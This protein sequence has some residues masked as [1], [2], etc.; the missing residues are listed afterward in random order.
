MKIVKPTL[1]L[2]K[3][4]CLNNIKS[5][6]AKAAAN[7]V[8][9]RPHFKT[10]QS[11]EVAEWFR[12]YNVTA[13]TV[14]SVE[15]AEYF[16]AKG[17]ED[18]TIAFPV[19]ILQMPAINALAR[20]ISLN[21]LVESEVVIKFLNLHL[22]HNCGVFVKIDTG[23]HRTGIPVADIT[24]VE[25]LAQM[26]EDSPKLHF[27]GLLV[28]N[29]NTYY[30]ASAEEAKKLTLAS[31]G[32]LANHV[33]YLLAKYP[34]MLVSIGDTPGCSIV[35]DFGIAGEIRPGNFVFYD[36]MQL[37]LGSCNF[38][39]IALIMVC[40]VVA[41]HKERNELV[42]YGGAVHLSKDFLIRQD[43]MIFGAV[44]AFHGNGWSNPI[45][46]AYVKSLSQEHGIVKLHPSHFPAFH[47]GDLIGIVPVHSC[48]TVSCM[49]KYYTLDGMIINTF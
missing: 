27:K 45:Q 12:E 33:P 22:Q 31:L 18:I 1:I 37:E 36:L 17:W 14:S 23:Y 19:N 21:L 40:P 16:A 20:R 7:Q 5:M 32:N 41:T 47:T 13:I 42:I 46:G 24:F 25:H 34:R 15:M 6:A 2:D 39:Q 38:G 26:A 9:F 44:V 49:K 28:H 3:Q 10:H 48:L 35:N 29:G 8:I 43:T 4:K 30:A 11:A